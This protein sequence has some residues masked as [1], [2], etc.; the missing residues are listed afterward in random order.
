MTRSSLLAAKINGN[1]EIQKIDMSSTDC[2]NRL[3]EER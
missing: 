1:C 3:S 2:D